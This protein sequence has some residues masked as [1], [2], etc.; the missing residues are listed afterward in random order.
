M[1]PNWYCYGQHRLERWNGDK[2]K[3]VSVVVK[4]VVYY[5]M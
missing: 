2:K 5:I 4:I 1:A 3:T